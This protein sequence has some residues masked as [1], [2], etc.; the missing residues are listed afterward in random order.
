MDKETGWLSRVSPRAAT[1]LLPTP[2]HQLHVQPGET[3]HL[4]TGIT[5]CYPLPAPHS[6][7]D[8]PKALSPVLLAD[9]SPGPPGFP[10]G[11]LPPATAVTLSLISRF[12]SCSCNSAVHNSIPFSSRS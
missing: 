4:R 3:T 6:S 11:L 7:S 5:L 8:I 2:H 1:E 9:V 12:I 10:W